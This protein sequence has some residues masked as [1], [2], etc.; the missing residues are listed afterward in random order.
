MLEF[1]RFIQGEFED[2]GDWLAVT[3]KD[4]GEP[5]GRVRT[6]GPAELERAIAGA[7]AASWPR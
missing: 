4:S 1:G 7:V 2:G 6:S 5:C 3:D